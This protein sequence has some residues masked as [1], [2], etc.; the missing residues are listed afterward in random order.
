MRWQG[1]GQAAADGAY[2]GTSFPHLLLQAYPELAPS[3]P[4]QLYV[5]RIYGFRVHGKSASRAQPS[6]T[7]S[8]PSKQ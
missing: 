2:F 5:P 6:A 8:P 3:E 4:L 1:E 7:S